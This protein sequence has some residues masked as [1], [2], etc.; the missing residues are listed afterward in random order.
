MVKTGP[1]VSRMPTALSLPLLKEESR[2]RGAGVA[3]QDPALGSEAAWR[4]ELVWFD[5]SDST[6]LLLFLAH[7]TSS[8]PRRPQ[9]DQSSIALAV[10][11]KYIVS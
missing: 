1:P 2:R 7:S 8:M 3:E 11:L 10:E 9:G 5:N 6:S 4:P